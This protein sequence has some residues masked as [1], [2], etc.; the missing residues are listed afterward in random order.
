MKKFFLF[1][2]ASAALVGCSSPANKSATA[3]FEEDIDDGADPQRTESPARTKTEEAPEETIYV[4]NPQSD[5]QLRPGM[6]SG[7]TVIIDFNADWCGPCRAFAPVF[8]AVAARTASKDVVFYSVNVD[9][10]PQTADAFGV[11]YI[12][13]VV[14][15]QPD[16]K[17]SLYQMEDLSS[18][19][20]FYNFVTNGK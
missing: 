15:I 11:Q 13:H 10:F 12:P 20:A 14:K 16:G 8:D 2:V 19:T 7:V 4:L 17:M 6:K 1:L 5:T 3:D 9:N 18:A